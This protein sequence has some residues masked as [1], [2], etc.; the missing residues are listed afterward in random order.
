ML[1]IIEGADKTGKTTLAQEISKRLGYKYVHF[2]VPGP[3]P[4]D[5]YAKF[6]IDLKEPTVCDRFFYGEMIYGPLLRGRSLI[7]PLQ[8]TVIERLCRSKSAVLIHAKTPL[9]IVSERLRLMGDDIITQEKNEAAYEAF[10]SLL[11]TSSLPK[12]DFIGLRD[13]SHIKFIENQLSLFNIVIKAPSFLTG[14]GTI[15]KPRVILVGDQLNKKVT[16]LNL[17]FDSGS[18]STFLDDCL[19][20]SKIK[21]SDIYIVNSDTLIKEEIVWFYNNL[22][23]KVIALG[24]KAAE[25]LEMFAANFK[26][27]AHPKRWKRFFSS[28]P[29]EYVTLLEKAAGL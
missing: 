5:E 11:A 25:R 10:E 6:L 15:D 17:P 27:I 9:A 23:V 3:S 19:R 18:S 29:E 14:I 24:N 28:K 16:W 26:V 12:L 1:I 21:E 22:E 2:G 4:A 8:R 20:K 13:G 7:K